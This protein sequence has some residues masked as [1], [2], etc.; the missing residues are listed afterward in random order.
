MSEVAPAGGGTGPNRIFILIVL[1]LAALLIIGLLA[2]GGI[3]LAQQL[4]KPGTAP[5]AA[6]KVST[7][8]QTRVIALALTP[9]LEPSG[10]PTVPATST[11]VLSLGTAVPSDLTP[12]VS[13]SETVVPGP[14]TPGAGTPGSNTLPKSGLGEDL[15]LLAG[16]VVLVLIIFA[17]RRARATT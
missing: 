10:T 16:G 2:V 9:T 13:V 11:P 6:V 4:T 14:G 3:F 8:T 1:G 5:T 17:A 7:A 15:L 12:T